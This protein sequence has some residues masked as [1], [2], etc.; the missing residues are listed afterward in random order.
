MINNIKMIGGKAESFDR[1]N[2]LKKSESSTPEQL[3]VAA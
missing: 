3:E 1:E 2:K